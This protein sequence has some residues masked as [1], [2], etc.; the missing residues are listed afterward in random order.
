LNSNQSSSWSST[1]GSDTI[2]LDQSIAL[3]RKGPAIRS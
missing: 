1:P 2:S 3:R